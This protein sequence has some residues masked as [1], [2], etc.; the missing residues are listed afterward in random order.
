M[1]P[2]LLVAVRVLALVST[3]LAAGVFLGHRRGVSV[4]MPQLD[5]ASFVQ[6]QQ[7]IHVQF[8]PMM[9]VL[10]FLAAGASIT[11]A[12][13][14]RVSADR[15]ARWL[16]GLAA[17]AMTAAL[18]LTLA[19]N[20]PINNTLMTWSVAAPPPDV[21]ALWQPWEVSHAIRTVLAFAAFVAQAVVLSRPSARPRVALPAAA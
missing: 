20:V 7:I 14:L 13:Q 8:V 4:A 21:R 12:L 6:L 18:A 11:W 17:A 5:P 19:I 9:P 16:A 10:L 1:T 2:M 3:G 15:I